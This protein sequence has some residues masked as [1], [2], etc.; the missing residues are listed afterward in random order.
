MQVQAPKGQYRVIGRG[1]IYLKSGMAVSAVSIR[2][3]SRTTGLPGH[4]GGPPGVGAE[5]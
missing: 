2:R 3:R 1:R 4:H 5:A